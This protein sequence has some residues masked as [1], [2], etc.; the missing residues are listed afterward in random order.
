M[1][2]VTGRG[3]VCRVKSRSAVVLTPDFEFVEIRKRPGMQTG[4]EVRFAAEDLVRYRRTGRLTALAASFVVLL[5]AAFLAFPRFS[6]EPAVYAYVGVEVNPGIELALDRAL[7]VVG[8]EALNAEGAG[9]L[10]ALNLAGMPAPEAVAGVVRA[11]LEQGYLGVGAEVRH[12]LVTTT[13]T[14][15]E[16]GT[17][18][19]AELLAA[20]EGELEQT[21]GETGV[22]LLDCSLAAREQARQAGLSPAHYVV[23]QKAVEQGMEPDP[24]AVRYGGLRDALALEGREYGAAVAAAAKMKVRAGRGGAEAEGEPWSPP[25][26]ERRSEEASGVPGKP[27]VKPPVKPGGKQVPLGGDQEPESEPEAGESEDV[28]GKVRPGPDGKRPFDVNGSNG[29]RNLR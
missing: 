20:I 16:G 25:G 1:T 3:V 4:Q 21:G 18:L 7:K 9:L 10:P 28:S 27:P 22:Y 13:L 6:P 2:G 12:L 29:N 15:E 23:W 19:Q 8:V 24:E 17:T 5:L 26:H 11:C 14:A